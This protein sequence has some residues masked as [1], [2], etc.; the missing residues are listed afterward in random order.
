[1]ASS[2]S[3]H[4]DSRVSLASLFKKR[5]KQIIGCMNSSQLAY[6]PSLAFPFLSISMEEKLK[7]P[8]GI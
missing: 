5:E 3:F 7:I 2:I 8:R 4:H 1:M 6:N